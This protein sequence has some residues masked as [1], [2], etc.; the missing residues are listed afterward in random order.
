MNC[1]EL[2]TLINNAEKERIAESARIDALYKDKK[3][4]T[5][6]YY[7][8]IKDKFLYRCIEIVVSTNFYHFTCNENFVVRV[9]L[10]N[11]DSEFKYTDFEESD[12][13]LF[14]DRGNLGENA[15]EFLRSF[16]LGG[17]TMRLE[18]HILN[19]GFSIK[20]TRFEEIHGIPPISI[21]HNL[22]VTS[23]EE[24]L[25]NF[26]CESETITKEQVKDNTCE[27]SDK[28]FPS[29]FIVLVVFSLVVALMMVVFLFK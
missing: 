14:G 5:E 29:W 8:L 3:A 19:N 27:S 4:K 20:K 11:I 9:L 15:I 18:K 17:L 7:E 13:T 22:L 24:L 25:K 1:D 2:N 28:D 12:L 16:N 6:E 23:K 21:R 26:C 10:D